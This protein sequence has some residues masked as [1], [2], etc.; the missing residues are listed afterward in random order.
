MQ[1]LETY[2]SRRKNTVENFIGVRTI[3]DLGL[4]AER[5]PGSRVSRRWW[6]QEGLELVGMHTALWGA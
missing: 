4:E 1:E 6:D 2:I 5:R 3:M